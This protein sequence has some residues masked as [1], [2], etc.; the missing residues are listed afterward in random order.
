MTIMRQ[1]AGRPGRIAQTIWK[2]IRGS[3]NR[4]RGRKVETDD[5]RGAGGF[6]KGRFETRWLAGWF[7][8]G[9]I[10]GGRGGGCGMLFRL[11]LIAQ[12]P[13]INCA[14]EAGHAYYQPKNRSPTIHKVFGLERRESDGRTSSV[15]GVFAGYLSILIRFMLI[16]AEHVKLFH[17]QVWWIISPLRVRVRVGSIL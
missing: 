13:K 17:H 3:F 4:I 9:G 15:P 11:P 12:S 5:G 14:E 10:C 7:G 8:A 16:R 6:D 1:L 2:R